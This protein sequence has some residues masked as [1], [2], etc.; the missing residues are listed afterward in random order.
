[1]SD[2]CHSSEADLVSL[3]EKKLGERRPDRLSAVGPPDEVEQHTMEQS[4]VPAIDV[5]VVH[6]VEQLVGASVWKAVP[7]PKM[8]D[9]WPGDEY[10]YELIS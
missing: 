2:D 4:I 6:M 10:E 3:Y 8:V 9:Q 7:V 1:M 5:H